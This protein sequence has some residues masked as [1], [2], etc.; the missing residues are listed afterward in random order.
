MNK[1]NLL[2]LTILG[3]ATVLLSLFSKEIFQID[4]L[5]LNSLSEQ[6]THEQLKSFLNFQKKWEWLTYLLI[7]LLLPIKVFIIASIIDVGCFFFSKEIKYKKLFNFVVKAEFMF[8]L[9]IVFKIAWFYFFQTDYSLEDLQYFYPL[10][11]LNII[12]YEGLQ[13]WFI[14]PLQALNLFE[15][16]YWLYLGYLISNELNIILDKAMTIIASS[17]GVSLLIWIVGVMFF[18]LN[19]S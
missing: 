17:Y 10:S 5:V 9:V 3:L 4:K 13:P 1:V 11:A 6:F 8:L 2:L 14:Y 12:G 19:M 15:L 18:T 7:L 16:F